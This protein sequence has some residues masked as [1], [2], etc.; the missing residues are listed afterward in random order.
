MVR[1]KV[2]KVV[3]DFK[4]IRKFCSFCVINKKKVVKISEYTRAEEKSYRSVLL[5]KIDRNQ[6]FV[7]NRLSYFIFCEL[8][9]VI[10]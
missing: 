4:D 1:G 3:I 7:L 6:G 2:K 9:G 10:F 8:E 5:S